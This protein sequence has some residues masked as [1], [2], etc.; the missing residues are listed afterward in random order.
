MH[1]EISAVGIDV[2]NSHTK[3]AWGNSVEKFPSVATRHVG[4]EVEDGSYVVTVKDHAGFPH[5]YLVGK[6]AIYSRDLSAQGVA[7]DY[8]KTDQYKAL[9]LGALHRV[10]AAHSHAGRPTSATITSMVVGL[11]MAN[12]AV[13]KAFLLNL[14]LGRHE[15][16]FGGTAVQLDV[17]DVLVV[18]QPAGAAFFHHLRKILTGRMHVDL[19][20]DMGGGT[21]DWAVLSGGIPEFPRCSSNLQAMHACTRE[22]M[23]QI[24]PGTV[25]SDPWALSELSIAL[26]T[27]APSYTHNGR[28]VRLEPLMPHVDRIV[29]SALTNMENGIKSFAGIKHIVVTG[30]GSRVLLPA[31]KKRYPD[32]TIV[33]DVEDPMT[34][35]VRGYLTMAKSRVA[36]K[37]TA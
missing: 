5:R 11:P 36:S 6:D 26:G 29:N 13:D 19:V 4:T 2:G 17:K 25:D 27:G 22:V 3:L 10:V 20:L 14:S 9:F 30:G 21:F 33:C 16:N 31:V 35:N 8:C 24:S 18:P 12:Y 7:R 1:V 23:L 37:A 15:L 32:M 28:A 34:T